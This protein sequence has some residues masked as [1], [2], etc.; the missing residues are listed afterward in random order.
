[1]TIDQYPKSCDAIASG[2]SGLFSHTGLA[3]L[4][5]KGSCFYIF[6][7]YWI[8]DC[9]TSGEEH[10]G[11]Q[12]GKFNKI[13]LVGNQCQKHKKHKGVLNQLTLLT[14]SQILPLQTYKYVHRIGAAGISG[15]GQ[16]MRVT[17]LFHISTEGFFRNCI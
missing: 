8:F 7:Y 2:F 11:G 17:E 6:L 12:G 3:A 5:S 13:L 4:Y 1:M 16:V 15:K 9:R 14:P 10:N